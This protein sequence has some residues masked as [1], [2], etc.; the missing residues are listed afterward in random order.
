MGLWVM[1]GQGSCTACVIVLE[2]DVL[3]AANLGDSGF[4][5]IRGDQVVYKSPAQ[6]HSFNFPFQLGRGGNGVFSL[7]TAADVS[8]AP[9]PCLVSRPLLYNLSDYFLTFAPCEAAM[10]L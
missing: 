10:P 1:W 4:M 8:P 5:V 7:P 2:R 9:Q 3:H 6:Q